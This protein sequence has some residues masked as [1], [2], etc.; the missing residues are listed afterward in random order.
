MTVT[1]AVDGMGGDFAPKEAVAGAVLAARHL[2]RCQVIL[3]GREAELRAELATH[4]AAPEIPIA[5]A[6]DVIGMQDHPTEAVKALPGASI[7]VGLGLVKAGQAQAFVTAGNTGATMAAALL[8]LGRVRGIARPALGL[9]YATPSGK[10]KLIIDVGANA[11]CRP[12]HL[13]QFAFMGSAFMERRYGVQAPL[14]GLLSI[15][16]EDTKGNQLTLDVNAALRESTLNFHGNVEANDILRDSVDV[17]VCDGFTGNVVLKCVEGVSETLFGEIRRA[18]TAR[19]WNR[20]AGLLLRPELRRVRARLDYTEYG[21]VQLLG[22]EGVTVIS[23]G[24]SNARAVFNAI[25]AARDASQ[26]GVLE[27]LREVGADMP[28]RRLARDAD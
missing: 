17:T 14:V 19:P 12:A 11:D 9:V 5:H 4:T 2:S 26:S 16:E 3:V 13:V 20:L 10:R 24:R 6:P 7:N 1:I 8:T 28:A 22:V 21:G 25:R 27:V 18:A 15:G 23:H